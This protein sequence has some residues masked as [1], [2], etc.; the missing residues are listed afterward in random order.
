MLPSALFFR[1]RPPRH[2]DDD[3][4]SHSLPRGRVRTRQSGF[5]VCTYE[6]QRGTSYNFMS[7]ERG[8][9]AGGLI[10]WV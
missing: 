8:V 6:S 2:D 10:L 1:R 5:P 9:V 4:D 7:Q 3:N